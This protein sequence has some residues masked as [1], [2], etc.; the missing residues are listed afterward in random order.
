MA[1]DTSLLKKVKV[2][3]AFSMLNMLKFEPLD[4]HREQI[5]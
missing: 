5:Q 4:W 2:L 1:C 3:S